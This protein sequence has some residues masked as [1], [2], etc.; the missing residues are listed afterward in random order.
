MLRHLTKTQILRDL[1]MLIT[2]LIKLQLI[3]YYFYS[4]D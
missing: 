2:A 1:K 4:K 3:C